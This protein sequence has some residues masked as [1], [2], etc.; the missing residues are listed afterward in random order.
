MKNPT[1]IGTMIGGP[2]DG[3]LLTFQS[4]KKLSQSD[5]DQ[6]AFIE[7]ENQIFKIENLNPREGTATFVWQHAKK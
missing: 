6:V 1:L 5:W 4:D 7:W 3:G 2:G